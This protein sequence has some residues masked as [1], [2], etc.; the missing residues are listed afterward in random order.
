M[1]ETRRD[2][3][4]T[5][6]A[7]AGLATFG[8]GLASATGGESVTFEEDFESLD[9]DWK[10]DTDLESSYF[11]GLWGAS[12]VSPPGLDTSL[13]EFVA[14]GAVTD[15]MVWIYAP[16]D[17]EP[18]TSYRG[19]FSMEMY[20]P[21]TT[22]AETT[23]HVSLGPELPAE[24]G[25]FPDEFESWRL[26]GDRLG[27]NSSL[28]DAEGWQ[29][30]ATYW[31]SPSYDTDTLYLA[32]GISTD[33]FT[34]AFHYLNELSVELAPSDSEDVVVND[35]DFELLDET[36]ER[37]VEFDESNDT[38]TI[39]DTVVAPTPC[40]ELDVSETEYDDSEDTLRVDLVMEE[41]D[42]SCIQ[43]TERRGYE[44]TVDCSSLPE[45][46]TVGAPTNRK[47][48]VANDPAVESVEL[49]VDDEIDSSHYDETLLDDADGTWS[50]GVHY[51]PANSVVHISDVVENTDASTVPTIADWSV[52]AD[53]FSVEMG[54]EDADSATSRRQHNI[55]VKATF[56]DG[57]PGDVEYTGPDA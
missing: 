29:E 52:D 5:A 13:V 42:Q 56:E 48:Y 1:R 47:R 12:L 45:T 14:D 19:K 4:R 38:I 11:S 32:V 33:E 49:F 36:P 40:H 44:V 23:L 43:K 10:V 26:Y 25:E 50:S 54:V 27:M 31:E 39:R 15:G 17:V 6:A 51:D 46:V 20:H 9:V 34:T 22:D 3:M 2:F 16:I 18:D 37:I 41:P 55:H 21:V 57:L 7:T 8:S 28:A 24:R 30:Y 53:T 35:T